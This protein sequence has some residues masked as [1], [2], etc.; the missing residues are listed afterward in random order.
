MFIETSQAPP[1]PPHLISAPELKR[2]ALL[3]CNS[4]RHSAGRTVLRELPPDCERGSW[5]SCVVG[6]AIGEDLAMRYCPVHVVDPD[7]GVVVNPHH[8]AVLSRLEY[9]FESG[10][11][12]GHYKPPYA[13]R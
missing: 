11:L 6:K 7:D 12:P 4:I 3:E 5:A 2:H 9:L 10:N 13:V 1:L 8:N